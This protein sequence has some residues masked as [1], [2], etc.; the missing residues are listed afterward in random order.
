MRYSSVTL[1]CKLVN[2]RDSTVKRASLDG[3]EMAVKWKRSVKVLFVFLE[4]FLRS[5]CL[6]SRDARYGTARTKWLSFCIYALV[7]YL[8]RYLRV[9]YH[10]NKVN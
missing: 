7:M 8:L 9:C 5:V 2:Y 6:A 10:L 4:L 3:E 1:W